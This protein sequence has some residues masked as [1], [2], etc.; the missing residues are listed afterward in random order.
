MSTLKP[1]MF[2][3]ALVLISTVPLSAQAAHPRTEV[4][5]DR[6]ELKADRREVRRDKRDRRQDTREL[7]RDA[8]D[9]RQNRTH[10]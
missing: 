2:G 7:R 3:A 9:A 4:R 1:L 6:R 8:R 5:R 10:N